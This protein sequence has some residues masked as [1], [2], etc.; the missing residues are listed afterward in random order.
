M[1]E[2]HVAVILA[3]LAVHIHPLFLVTDV[4]RLPL[5]PTPAF[6]GAALP[7]SGFVPARL[8]TLFP[9]YFTPLFAL[10]FVALFPPGLF[11]AMPGRT[12]AVVHRAS[13]LLALVFSFWFTRHG[14][15][16]SSVSSG[17]DRTSPRRATSSC[18]L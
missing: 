12:V 1:L 8:S 9:G 18:P 17:G 13:A 6:F 2:V 10:F 11:A 15:C 3:V 7:A 14:L 4:H 16:L 5:G